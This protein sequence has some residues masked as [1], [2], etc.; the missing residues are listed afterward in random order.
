LFFAETLFFG[1]IVIL[2][3]EKNSFCSNSQ[4]AGSKSGLASVVG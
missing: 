2:Q 3:A 4:I 1:V